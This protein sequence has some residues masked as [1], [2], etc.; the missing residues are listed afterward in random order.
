MSETGMQ[1]RARWP[2]LEI[3]TTVLHA[4]Q[5]V[6]AIVVLGLAVYGV[7]HVRYNVLIYSLVVALCTNL[8]CMYR[9]IS[10]TVLRKLDNEYVALGLYI[11]M[12]VLWVVDLGLVAN[13]A[14]VWGDSEC[15]PDSWD[16]SKCTIHSKQHVYRSATSPHRAY[17]KALIA[18]ACLAAVQVVLWTATIA[19][20]LRVSMNRRLNA[21]FE[22]SLNINQPMDEVR[23]G[24]DPW[25][26][27]IPGLRNGPL[28]LLPSP[29]PG[30]QG[31]KSV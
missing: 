17:H 16:G 19:I 14:M 12:F 9:F 24:N 1:H 20:L 30:Y 31:E 25:A 18:I 13:L 2:L 22:A 15:A 4:S 6:L 11:W 27:G 29:E 5:L 23:A 26:V 8:V 21:A 3:L 28:P 10:R 7:Q